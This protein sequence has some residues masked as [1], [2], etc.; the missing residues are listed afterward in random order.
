ML[1]YMAAEWALNRDFVKYFYLLFI[2]YTYM[3]IRVYLVLI[4]KLHAEIINNS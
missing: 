4:E 1:G 3:C 2:L